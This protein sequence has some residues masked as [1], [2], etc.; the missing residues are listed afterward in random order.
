MIKILAGLVVVLFLG[1][2]TSLFFLKHEVSRAATLQSQYNTSQEGLRRANEE[3]A[4]KAKLDKATDAIVARVQ[5]DTS[6]VQ[7]I[8][9]HIKEK[10]NVTSKKEAKGEI[11][12]AVAS[13]IYIDSM[14]ETYCQANIPDPHCPSK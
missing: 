7:R 14:W 1:L 6:K 10:V 9:S 3:L 8:V 2:A 11:S 12:P 13:S 5:D 4:R